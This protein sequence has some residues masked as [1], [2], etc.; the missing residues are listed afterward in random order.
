VVTYW[1]PSSGP[2]L[3]EPFAFSYTM[4]WYSDDQNRPPGGKAVSTRRDAG[5]V[6]DAQRFV[7][8]FAS[9]KLAGI[10]ADR[11]LRGVVTVIGGPE[12]GEIIDQHVAP[13][14]HAGGWRLTF[15]VHPKTRTALPLRAF[16]DEGGDTL[17]ETWSYALMP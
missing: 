15:Q 1:V 13:N 6:K 17:T 14:P 11:V 8:D 2:K 7:I 4:Y 12:A 10:P 3:G 5:T 9:K 16:L